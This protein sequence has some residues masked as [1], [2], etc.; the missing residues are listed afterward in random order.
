MYVSTFLDSYIN[1]ESIKTCSESESDHNS[2]LGKRKYNQI[3]SFAYQK[4]SGERFF[5]CKCFGLNQIL[6]NVKITTTSPGI[7]EV[8][9]I[10]NK[11]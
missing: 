4:Q 8:I 5:L 2:Q 7:I 10:F 6:L 1:C 3:D 9:K 11:K